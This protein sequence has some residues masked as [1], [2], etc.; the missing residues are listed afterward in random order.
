[1][2][3]VTTN[4]CALSIHHCIHAFHCLKQGSCSSLYNLFKNCVFAFISSTDYIFFLAVYLS[5]FGTYR[6]CMDR[7]LANKEDARTQG[8]LCSLKIAPQTG[9]CGVVRCLCCNS[10]SRC[11]LTFGFVKRSKITVTSLY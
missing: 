7:D 1:M 2:K 3:I 10:G 4:F 8:G 5:L 9:H 6:S 11:N